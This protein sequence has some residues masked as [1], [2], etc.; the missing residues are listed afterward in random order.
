[1]EVQDLQWGLKR[2]QLEGQQKLQFEERLLQELL[3]LEMDQLGKEHAL[4]R[5]RFE[6][7]CC[8]QVSWGGRV[9]CL[10]VGGSYRLQHSHLQIEQDLDGHQLH[11]RNDYQLKRQQLKGNKETDLQR[12]LNRTRESEMGKRHTAERKYFPRLQRQ[13]V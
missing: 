2:D 11:A 13:K 8:L 4:E 9:P 3:A 1:M 10:G 7:R 6:V 12:L 5:D